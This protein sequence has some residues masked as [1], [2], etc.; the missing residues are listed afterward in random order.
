MPLSIQ[1]FID[2]LT[3]LNVLPPGELSGIRDK[4]TEPQ[5]QADAET[6]AKDL[7]RSGK[8]T[9]YQAAALYNGRGK[10]L[11]FGEYVVLDKLGAGGMGQVFKAQHRR[12]KRMVALKVLP[13]H[14][15][16]SPSSV[17][18]FYKEV[19][20]AAKLVHPNIVTA[21]DAGESHGL[22]YMVMEYVEGQDLSSIIAK[23]GPLTV[24]QAMNCIRQAADGLQ[25]AHDQGIIHRD[26]KPAN[27]LV[28]KKGKVKLLD[29]GL[30]RTI[31]TLDSLDAAANE[32]L[33]QEG[34][35][36]GTVDYMAPEQAR[37]TR[38]ADHRADVYSLGCA[39][40][41]VLTGKIPYPADTMVKKILAHVQQ[42]IPSLRALRPE[43][44]SGLDAL[45]Q[46]M[47]AK[48]P[49]QRVQ[50]ASEVSAAIANLM[51]G[52][53]EE[54]SSVSVIE[55]AARDDDMQSFLKPTQATAGGATPPPLPPRDS[56][57]AAAG[58][59]AKGQ[60]AATKKA[61]VGLLAGVGGGLVAAGIAVFMFLNGSSD[62]NSD[63]RA[64]VATS[65]QVTP[66]VEPTAAP[67]TAAPATTEPVATDPANA[68]KA[69]STSSAPFDFNLKSMPAEKPTE[70]TGEKP[71][72][73]PAP[74]PAP[75]PT[76]VPTPAPAPTPTPTPPTPVPT[77]A[78]V[79]TETK[80]PMS[81][82][83]SPKS[84]TNALR[85]IDV[86][87]DAKV[88]TWA[89]QEGVLV[90]PAETPHR[91]FLQVPFDGARDF[92]LLVTVQKVDATAGLFGVIV[93]VEG[94]E[95]CIRFSSETLIDNLDYEKG[96]P[97]SGR[98][99][100]NVLPGVE[101]HQVLIQ[102][103]GPSVQVT[104]DGKLLL[105]WRG[106]AAQLQ[107]V[108][109]CAPKG[110]ERRILIESHAAVHHILKLDY[111]P[112]TATEPIVLTETTS[113]PRDLLAAADPKRDSVD[114][115]WVRDRDAV[116]ARYEAGKLPRVSLPGAVIE[117]Y[118]VTAIVQRT[119]PQHLGFTLPVRG[120]RTCGLLDL[121]RN[122]SGLLILGTGG[123]D[124]NATPFKDPGTLLLP[125]EPTLVTW[126]V[127]ARKIECH[128]NG[129]RTIFW[130]GSCEQLLRDARFEVP[131]LHSFALVGD[132]FRVTKFEVASSQWKPLAR[133]ATADVDAAE[134][135][136]RQE[137]TLAY[138]KNS[139]AEI[140]RIAA[141]SLRRSAARDTSNPALRFARLEQCIELAAGSGDLVT[142]LLALED[143]QASYAI[144]ARPYEKS[145]VT[146]SFKAPRP[147]T[148]RQGLNDD[149]FRMIDRAL[150]LERFELAADLLTAVTGSLGKTNTDMQ[151]E[152]RT[153]GI[154]YKHWKTEWDAAEKAREKLAKDADT[155]EAHNVLGRYLGLVRGDWHAAHEH[156]KQGNDEPWTAIAAGEVAN[157]ADPAE[158]AALG[159]KWWAMSEKAAAPLKSL[160]QERG[161][162]WYRLASTRLAGAAKSAVEKRREQ[163]NN[164]RKATGALFATR[165]PIDAQKIGDRWYK[166]YMDEVEWDM[167]R[168][169]C[170]RLGGQLA[171]IESA[172]E[173]Q[174]VGQFALAECKR[175]TGQER[176]FVWIGLSD[177]EVEGTFR[178]TNGKP[179]GTTY[180]GW[181]PGQPDN[182]GG[183][184][185]LVGLEAVF[186]AGQVAVD[187]QDMT[188]GTRTNF[189]CEWE[190]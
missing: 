175:L 137:Q 155:T 129:R 54:A 11:A 144:D 28:D 97:W 133:P 122:I 90:C 83:P 162:R 10:G 119:G 79:P 15:M 180:A 21:F 33:T 50:S 67:T 121:Y 124:I 159:D 31:A 36:M 103:A 51:A 157:P 125:G 181:R 69:E 62:G 182:A 147:V 143:L 149:A 188:V 160:Y 57:K 59:S 78:P 18:R 26:I 187:W 81:P 24:E 136:V 12:M 49:T 102:V 131:D 174:A 161:D 104:V 114:G 99:L 47:V 154:E 148:A 32:G 4:L 107:E 109:F 34:Q 71:A 94:R 88:G 20:L 25:Y 7:V 169:I 27:M 189:I 101:P 29:M 64:F 100:Q 141:E 44:P 66:F 6:L 120:N 172:N 176:V 58:N 72:A 45:F 16:N 132:G 115:E 190:W 126:T 2:S 152:L 105:H 142:A 145:A 38:Q 40:Y 106:D 138:E 167:A 65:S 52:C 130:N 150:L 163:L 89:M 73:M 84:L 183:T 82:V 37:D 151:K 23:S 127:D 170:E 46:R 63:G 93:P 123:S 35:V 96:A 179:L 41:R 92:S 178:W 48:D 112:A 164:Q 166:T 113:P 68:T 74:A 158:Q 80:A 42:P 165:H 60:P 116:A 98:Y 156:L 77:P 118:M 184:E 76:P 95:A 13:P 128:V 1:Q 85:L 110:P 171:M 153:R 56:A 70:P 108:K 19:E 30:A 39:L 91:G 139:K 8:L 185:D 140:R 43:V 75:T 14:A 61:P 53:N 5:L 134:S 86:A 87:R 117:P 17:Q 186:S 55:E 146:D 177:T 135:I 168:M 111:R 22:H 9:K 3:T 173:N